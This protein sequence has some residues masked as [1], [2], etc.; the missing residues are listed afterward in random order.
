MEIRGR[1]D[2]IQITTFWR[3]IWREKSGR[4]EDTCSNSNSSEKPP[5]NAGVKTRLKCGDRDDTSNLMIRECSKLMQNEYKSRL[6][7][8]GKVIHKE[9]CK[10]FKFG[11]TI[12]WYMHY[13]KSIRENETRKILKDFEI[14][15]DPLISPKRLDL[16]TKEN[17]PNSGLS[18]TS[19]PQS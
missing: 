13:P 14:P 4:L 9:L 1:I 17:L 8:I 18:D 3:S 7:W 2:T 5:T 19:G 10:K 12:K 11:H 15:T 16:T 6:D